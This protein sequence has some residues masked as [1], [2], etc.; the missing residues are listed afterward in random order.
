MPSLEEVPLQAQ[1]NIESGDE[2]IEDTG[3]K[4]RLPRKAVLLLAGVCALCAA[5][6]FFNTKVAR[7]N[8][9]HAIAKWDGD[10][11]SSQCGHMENNTDYV[12]FSGWG[13]NLDHIPS[14]D[15]CCAFCQANPKC[16]SFVWVADAGL[17]GCP[18]QCWLKGGKPV[19]K[20]GKAGVVAGVPPP[21]IEFGVAPQE[22]SPDEF[23]L[24]RAGMF[25]F[26]LM[27]PFGYEVDL[28]AWQYFHQVSI[29]ACDKFAVYTNKS[30]EVGLDT[31]LYTHVVDSDLHC[32]LGGDSYSA[33]NSWI[34]IAVWKKVLDDGYWREYP[35]T[36]KVDPDAVFLPLRARPILM[37]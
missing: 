6:A 3:S 1:L 9:R 2:L 13:T 5:A 12:E 11:S 24:E 26:S 34:F 18:S 14:P 37:Q 30:M 7:S 29:F 10:L 32:G 23:P 4:F 21:R 28:L 31:G 19:Q 8:A 35:W 17:D 20:K 25:C 36:V 27:L 22:A 33:L 16:K 15:M